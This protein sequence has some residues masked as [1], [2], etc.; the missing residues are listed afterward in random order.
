MRILITGS[1]NWTDAQAIRDAIATAIAGFAGPVTI[2]HGGA[3]G[4]DQLAAALAPTFGPHVTCELWPA[5]WEGPCRDECRPGHRR[6]R[7]DRSSYCPAAGNFRNQDM[8]DAGTTVCLGFPLGTSR[9]TRDC[10]RRA[11]KAGIP[12]VIHEGQADA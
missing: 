8:V 10:L 3:R 1:R 4:A 11:G 9:G 2:I 6:S 5:D 7:H 12:T